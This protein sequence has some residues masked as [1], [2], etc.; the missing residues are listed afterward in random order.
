MDVLK[1]APDARAFVAAELR[2]MAAGRN[3]Y[4]GM[5]IRSMPPWCR[6]IWLAAAEMLLNKDCS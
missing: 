6:H 5:S 3:E 2:D 4:S 1:T